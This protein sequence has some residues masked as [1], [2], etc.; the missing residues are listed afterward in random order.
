M[1]AVVTGSSGFIGRNLAERL[2]RDGHQ[3]RCLVRPGSV[4]PEGCVA[5]GVDYSDPRGLASSPAFEGADLIFHLAGV[6]RATSAAAFRDGNVRPTRTLL[7]ALA[8]RGVAARLVLVSSQAAAGPAESLDRPVTEDDTP[9]PVEHYGWSKLEAEN[10][11]RSFSD[12]IPITVVRPCAVYGPV[13]RDFLKLFR[14]ATRGWMV[15]PGVRRHWLS[16]LHVDDV[17]DGILAAADRS[18]SNGRTYFLASEQP[19]QWESVGHAIE[20]ALGRPLR[21][22]N[23]PHP[24]ITLGALLSDAAGALLG[25]TSLANRSKAKLSQSPH[26]ICSGER[27]RR[28][29]GFAPRRSLPEGVRQTYLWYRRNGWLG[30]MVG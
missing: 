4:P 14:L 19:V 26:W 16:L 3:V 17:V 20:N 25:T 6:T 2:L 29:L 13:D 8:S 5:H 7:E 12:R 28:E 10:V 22:V 1:I 27:A 18:V 9:R 21:H 15:Y 23:L 11:A 24:L 30:A